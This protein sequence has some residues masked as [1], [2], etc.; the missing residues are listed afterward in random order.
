MMKKSFLIALVA[1]M[2]AGSVAAQQ[3]VQPTL[4]HG[5]GQHCGNCKHHGQ[6]GGPHAKKQVA[7]LPEMQYNEDG[8]EV[9]LLKAYPK[10]KSIKKDGNLVGVYDAKGKLMGFA[11]YSKPASDDIKG[12]NG[13]TPVLVTLNK[14]MVITGVYALPNMETPRFAQRVEEAGF[15]DSWNGMTFKEALK[16]EVDAVSGATF[17]SMAVAKSVRAALETL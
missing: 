2:A 1:L 14:K 12:F 16:K 4:K 3:P 10:A 5:S 9:T 7:A 13:E 17:T 11:V 15:Y 6:H 8:I